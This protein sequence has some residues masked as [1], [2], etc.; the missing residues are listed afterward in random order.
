MALRL[1]ISL[2]RFDTRSKQYVFQSCVQFVVRCAPM[3]G[4]LTSSA[5]QGMLSEN[6]ELLKAVMCAPA[7]VLYKGTKAKIFNA[8]CEEVRTPITSPSP[9]T[10][11]PNRCSRS[12][13]PS[14]SASSVRTSCRTSTC[15]RRSRTTACVPTGRW[16]WWTQAGFNAPCATSPIVWTSVACARISNQGETPYEN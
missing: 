5:S 8:S 13:P 9:S 2:Y 3:P 6:M 11:T 10:N 7:V 4:V 15:P 12:R 14:R 16:C 1:P